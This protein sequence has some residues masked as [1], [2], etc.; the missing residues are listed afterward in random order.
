MFLH[1]TLGEKQTKQNRQKTTTTKT[2]TTTTKLWLTPDI[3]MH[4]NISLSK[5]ELWPRPRLEITMD[6]NN[7]LSIHCKERTLAKPG[8]YVAYLIS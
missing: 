6:V 4:V 7:S 2:K 3:T 5:Q 1:Q 8:K